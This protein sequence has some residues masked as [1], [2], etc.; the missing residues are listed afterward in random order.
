MQIK[1]LLIRSLKI[2]IGLIE[3]AIIYKTTSVIF[4][5]VI[6]LEESI[7]LTHKAQHILFLELLKILGL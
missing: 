4:I 7:H 2:Q 3:K 6:L 1:T 5:Q